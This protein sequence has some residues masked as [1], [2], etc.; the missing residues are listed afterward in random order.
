MFSVLNIFFCFILGFLWFLRKCFLEGGCF[1]GDEYLPSS[2]LVCCVYLLALWINSCLAALSVAACH[3]VESEKFSV[4]QNISWSCICLPHRRKS[5]G[6][7]AEAWV[8]LL[9]AFFFLRGALRRLLSCCLLFHHREAAGRT[10]SDPVA[11]VGDTGRVGDCGQW[12][13]CGACHRCTPCLSSACL[14]PRAELPVLTAS[15]LMALRRD[16]FEVAE[17][18]RSQSCV[19]F[20]DGFF[21]LTPFLTQELY[22]SLWTTFLFLRYTVDWQANRN[23]FFCTVINMMH[24][25]SV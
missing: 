21:S 19:I 10:V 7:K 9:K 22:F 12:W 24:V 1:P 4:L 11:M 15:R 13:P 25:F 3:V 5:E 18:R 16:V 14:C 17:S 6:E 8:V 20:R 23:L 2:L